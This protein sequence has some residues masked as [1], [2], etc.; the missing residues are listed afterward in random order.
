MNERESPVRRDEI[1]VLLDVRL[2]D[3]AHALGVIDD[4][5]R[6]AVKF[7]DLLGGHIEKRGRAA[8]VENRGHVTTDERI[9]GGALVRARAVSAMGAGAI[10]PVPID[11]R[12]SK[13]V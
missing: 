8:R 3:G 13:V 5:P 2:D 9:D 7:Y 11:D 6:L 4:E 12:G 1:A 10:D